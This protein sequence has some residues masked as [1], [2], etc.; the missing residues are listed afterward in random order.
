MY[1]DNSSRPKVAAEPAFAGRL[2]GHASRRQRDRGSRTEQHMRG[3]KPVP[4][5]LREL[6]GNPRDHAMP[7][8]EPRPKGALSDAPGW[9]TGDQQDGWTYA[10]AFAPPGLLTRI[11][12]GVLVA[13]IVA[14]DLHRQAATAQAKVGLLVR[15]KTKATAAPGDPGV[16]VASPY[17]NIINRQAQIMM[18]AA[19]E[20]G[21]TPVSRP[22]VSMGAPPSGEEFNGGKTARGDE[23]A[24]SF[25]A[26]LDADPDAGATIQ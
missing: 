26:F 15:V 10:L 23:A 8:G 12:R 6:H 4:T 9:L 24:R 22:R 17:L 18:K 14:E 19:S 16:A 21:F 25:G 1:R 3:R 20:L 11:D 7:K 2:S 13:W 5:I